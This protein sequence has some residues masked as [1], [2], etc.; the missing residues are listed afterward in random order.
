MNNREVAGWLV[1]LVDNREYVPV[2]R[3]RESQGGTLNLTTMLPDQDHASIELFFRGARYLE[4]IHTFHLDHLRKASQR[5]RIILSADVRGLVHVTLRVEGEIREERS[6]EIPAEVHKRRLW[7]VLLALLLILAAAGATA[8]AIQSPFT[9]DIAAAAD[10]RLPTS[11]SRSIPGAVDLD[12]ALSREQ[13]GA[14]AREPEAEALT[15][16]TIIYFEPESALLLPEA[17][18]QVASLAQ[19][20]AD[21]DA[22]PPA[23]VARGHTALFGNAGA[24]L[25][26]SRER[27]NAVSQA[28]LRELGE[29]GIDTVT[30]E[31]EGLGG[32]EPVTRRASEQWRNRRVELLTQRLPR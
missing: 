11:G 14:S 28:L 21:S 32:A 22:M 19:R 6:F 24:R 2:S 10:L 4:H 8:L 30:I 17:E 25:T 16:E 20:I 15:V 3:L 12:Q 18:A 26:L 7:P 31:V 29:R 1:V 27:A 13:T 5:P 23:L 9:R